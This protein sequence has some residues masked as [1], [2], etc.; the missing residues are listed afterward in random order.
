M[1]KFTKYTS[2]ALVAATG[3]AWLSSCDDSKDN[4]LYEVYPGADAAGA[5]FPA[6]ANTEFEVTDNKTEF[7]FPDFMYRGQAGDAWS[8][9]VTVTPADDDVVAE[10]FEFYPT[11]TFSAGAKTAPFK[12]KCDASLLEKEVEQQFIV[13]IN[14]NYDSPLGANTVVITIWR[15]GDWEM[16]GTVTYTDYEWGISLY[17]YSTEVECWRSLSPDTPNLYRINNPYQFIPEDAKKKFQFQILQENEE[18][19]D[20][21]VTEPNLVGYPDFR[22]DY[23]SDFGEDLYILFPGRFGVYANPSNWVYNYVDSYQPDGTFGA[24]VLSPMYF[25]F[26]SQQ[27]IDDTK[28]EPISIVF[29]GY[30]I[31]DTY[32]AVTY[33]GMTIKADGTYEVAVDVALGADVT[34]AK[35]AIVE[36]TNITDEI[37]DAISN[38]EIESKDI[39][40]GQELYLPFDPLSN[41][42]VYSVVAITYIEDEIKRVSFATFS[43][44]SS[45][46]DTWDFVGVGTYT[47]LS[48]WGQFGLTSDELNLYESST[49][50]GKFKIEDW[51]FGEDFVFYMT[52]NGDI[53]VLDQFT[54]AAMDP[55]GPIYVDDVVDY[56]GTLDYGHS[57]LEN[58]VYNF[59]V[60]YYASGGYFDYGYETFK[61]KPDSSE[62]EAQTKS[63]KNG[64][65]KYLDTTPIHPY[66]RDKM[67]KMKYFNLK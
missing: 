46:Y 53:T 65:S 21:I 67:R 35:V 22:I 19:L 45:V 8:V 29:P 47:Y 61:L 13:E 57:Y 33:N 44:N 54:G 6:S 52:S 63:L 26:D 23:I 42:G 20:E 51:F 17:S 56:F 1:K 2:I 43:Y 3:G 5:Y 24:I 32:A 58:G 10:A 37:V 50:P 41:A 36:G 40:T 38:G 9:P 60:I 48:F 62:I 49:N 27:G 7:S 11:V 64:S 34:S 14:P 18:Y 59:N 12:F 31:L 15:E 66:R 39:R 16:I 55:Y 28:A 30:E 25:L 4:D